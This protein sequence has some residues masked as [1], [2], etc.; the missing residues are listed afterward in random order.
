MMSSWSNR[1]RFVPLAALLVLTMLGVSVFLTG[2]SPAAA[3]GILTAPANVNAVSNS[4]GE[5]TLTWEGGDNADYFLLIAADMETFEYEIANVSDAA[6]RT[7]TV[8]GLTRGATYLGIVVALQATADGLMTQ[9]GAARPVEVIRG[10]DGAGQSAQVACPGPE[11]MVTPRPA[12]TVRGDYDAD[13]DGL[14]EVA[15]LAQLDAI[16]YDPGGRGSPSDEDLTSYY[17]AFPNAAAGMGCPESG[18][19]GYELVTDLDFDTNGNGRADAG[20][21]YWNNGEGWMPIS[22]AG[23][24]GGGGHTISNL[25]ISRKD[26]DNIGLFASISTF[27]L[28]KFPRGSSGEVSNLA[29]TNVK[30]SGGDYVGGLVGVGMVSGSCVSGTVTG[31]GYVGLLAGAAQVNDSFAAGTVVGTGANVGGLVGSGGKISRSYAVSTVAGEGSNVG[32][33]AGA[34]RIVEDSYATGVVVGARNNVGGLVGANHKPV[35]R[36]IGVKKITIGTMIVSASYSESMVTGDGDNVGGLVGYIETP[37]SVSSIT[38]S[39]ATGAVTGGRD[40]VG[41]LV[42]FAKTWD[43]DGSL[44]ITESYATG[45]VTG[46]RSQVG[47]LVG[48]AAAGYRGA[49]L[50]IARSYAMGA[51]TA[52]GS[53]VGGLVGWAERNS[54]SLRISESYASGKVAAGGG[55]VGGLVG[56]AEGFISGSYASGDV[57]GSKGFLGGLAGR[58]DGSVSQSSA[59]GKVAGSGD[60]VGGLVGAVSPSLFNLSITESYATGPV[61]GGSNVGG[62]V[63]AGCRIATPVTETALHSTSVAATL[64]AR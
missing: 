19:V 30:V 17:G 6:A 35:L 23:H 43:T 50:E 15:N 55:H 58:L 13:D 2:N 56:L 40:N 48:H 46:R 36:A 1:L 14:I 16:R 8:T 5:L 25:F 24:F 22:V 52:G 3:Q 29:M 31:G 59:T 26:D 21:V 7:G 34:A 11:W 61:S 49:E 10:A 57:S 33:L 53:A 37:N 63:G 64:R 18:C 54:S 62:L 41:G 42:G 60:G 39:Y 45:A 28:F 32:G 4:A 27:N 12:P 38:D 51:V 44:S 20:D 47:G 9:Y